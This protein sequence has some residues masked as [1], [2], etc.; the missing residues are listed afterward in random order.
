M[1]LVI[2]VG[3]AVRNFVLG[4]AALLKHEAAPGVVTL[5]LVILLFVAFA[6][7]MKAASERRRA[8]RWLESEISTATDETD[9]SHSLVEVEHRIAGHANS[10]PRKRVAIAW[11]EYRETLV[12]H[13]EDG[14]IILRNAVRPSIFFNLDDLGFGAGFWRIIPGIF[15]SVGLFLTFLGLVAALSSMDL[16]PDNVQASLRALLTIAS[17]KFIMSLTGLLCSIIF[18]IT[19]RA[20]IGSVE[21]A[22]HKLCAALEQRLTFIS[23]EA[24]AAEQLAA[25]RESRE[26]FQKIGFEMVAEF[27]RPLREELPAAISSSIS[28]AMSPLL[29]QIGQVGADGMGSMVKDLSSRFSDDVGNALSHASEKLAQAGDRIGDL[30]SRMDQSSGR[31]GAE[32][33]A[34]IARLTQAVDDLRTSMGA[35]ADSTSGAFTK[36]AEHLLAVMNQTLEGIRDNT[37]EGARAMSAA[38]TDMRQAAEGFRTELEL[39]ARTGSEA[40]KAQMDAASSQAS[41]AIGTAGR[42]VLD[43]I[44]RTTSEISRATE[45]LT[46]KASQDLFEPLEKISAQLGSMVANLNEGATG[47]RR[48]SDGVR[49]GAEASEQA[50]VSFRSASGD[51]VSAVTPV[52]AMNERMEASIRQLTESTQNAVATVTRSSQTTAESAASTLSAAQA[53]LGGEA[54]AIEASLAGVSVMLDRMK[55]Q[56]DRLDDMDAKLGKAFEIYTERVDTAVAGMFEHVRKMQSELS[57]ALDT[58]QTI[59]DQAEQ[60]APESRRR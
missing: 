53:V 2:E 35:T 37:G 28:A 6:L 38:A 42:D 36:G 43:A 22:L 11:K 47:M 52:R 20:G 4:L 32:M 3:V 10:E 58:L 45:S 54:R 34:S 44:G 25:T 50:A 48:L 49:A 12:P 39:A 40:A 41:G 24:L 5:L 14:R 57:P 19:L 26:H 15:V 7:F 16:T 8:L 18:T 31:M 60:F 33:D 1:E 56:G 51:L 27:G 30:A 21:S 55:G 13:E 17:A 59:V 46:A 23:L 9:F 29:Q